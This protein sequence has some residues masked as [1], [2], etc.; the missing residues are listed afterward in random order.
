MQPVQNNLL[1]KFLAYSEAN[2]IRVFL[3][4]GSLVAIIAWADWKDE[5]NSLGFLYILPILLASG[6]L[7]G[8]QILAFST[9]CAI[10]RELFNTQ[11]P[12]PGVP[13]RILI[14]VSGFALAGFFVS[15]L[16]RKRQLV[17]QHLA[18]REKQMLLRQEA[19]QQLKVLIET[20]PLAVLT[21]DGA[22]KILI[23]NESAQQLLGFHQEPA[24]GTDIYACMPILKRF[25]GVSHSDKLRTTV[26]TKGQRRDGEVFLAHVWLST[27]DT[28]S[29]R[30]L[31]AFVWDASENLR[32]REGTG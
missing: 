32:D 4:A 8:W 28:V 18:A 7:S 1:E 12:Q 23:T 21:I 29:G 27:Y 15:E 24:Q 20:S 11:H 3:A 10:L 25:L 30:R 22:G 26:E 13:Q 16:N 6:T 19:E 2:R 5:A 17:T 31:A 9:V 14:G